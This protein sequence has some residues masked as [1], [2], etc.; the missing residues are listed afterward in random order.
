[1]EIYIYSNCIKRRLDP[2]GKKKKIN[3][4]ITL[5]SIISLYLNLE[6]L[7]LLEMEPRLTSPPLDSTPVPTPLHSPLLPPVVCTTSVLGHDGPN[8]VLHRVENNEKNDVITDSTE[9]L[10]ASLRCRIEK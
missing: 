10:P 4:L 1:M 9:L 5:R 7:I 3:H 8:Y 2:L 6:K